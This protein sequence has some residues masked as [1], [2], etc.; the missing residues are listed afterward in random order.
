MQTKAKTGY[1]CK[2]LACIFLMQ[3]SE[4]TVN[5]QTVTCTTEDGISFTTTASDR[6][7]NTSTLCSTPYSQNDTTKSSEI[8]NSLE[9]SD[10]ADQMRLYDTPIPS[11]AVP[12]TRRRYVPS[13]P[14]ILVENDRYDTRSSLPFHTIMENV[15]RASKIDPMF[16]HAIAKTESSYNRYAVSHAG[17]RGLMQLM[18]ATARRYGLFTSLSELHDP[19]KNVS[20]S[21][22]YLKSLQ[23][24]YGNNLSLI[25][26]AYNAGE[27]AVAKYGN[28]IPPYRET[29]DYVGRVL[30]NYERFK[31][32]K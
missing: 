22:S 24:R 26:A 32:R 27:G 12:T 6:Y 1:L 25:L 30:R 28:T 4:F 15:G 14:V 2:S 16:L 31:L 7:N 9:E 5:A 8:V 20:A 19:L 29:Q 18:P 21:A 11:I 17:A 23:A 13:I 10:Y 3:L